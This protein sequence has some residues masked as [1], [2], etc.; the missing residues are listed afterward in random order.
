MV[1]Q[2][3][4]IFLVVS[5]LL[6][7]A[8]AG[9]QETEAPEADDPNDQ[10]ENEENIENKE[11]PANGEGA[12]ETGDPI[13]LD[14]YFMNVTETS[15][16]LDKETRKLGV[17]G[18][19]QVDLEEVIAE[20]LKGPETEALSRVIPAE[21]RLLG[22]SQENGVAYVDFSE[23]L[24]QAEVGSEAEAVLVDSIVKTLTQL[25]EVESVQILVEGEVIESIAGHVTID[26]PLN[27]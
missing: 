14:I 2:V 19:P 10:V 8:L 7:L 5:L 25:E 9:C 11:Q 4:L 23:E 13:M 3:L 22:I 18:G 17:F 16:E 27:Y 24:L 15:F 12:L 20:L 21:T 26:K 1:R 6:G